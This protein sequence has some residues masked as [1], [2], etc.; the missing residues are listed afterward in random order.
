MDVFWLGSKVRIYVMRISAPTS[1][2]D[3]GSY[4]FILIED[5]TLTLNQIHTLCRSRFSSTAL[6]HPALF[7]IGDLC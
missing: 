2:G 1:W 3:S 7:G 6:L 4:Q 5:C